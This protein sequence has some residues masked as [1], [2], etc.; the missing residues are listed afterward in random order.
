M[1]KR[2]GQERRVLDRL[3]VLRAERRS[4]SLHHLTQRL[5]AAGAGQLDVRR[6]GLGD[7]SERVCWAEDLGR[8][9]DRVAEGGRGGVQRGIDRSDDPIRPAD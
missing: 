6:F 1:V 8:H 9:R 5:V 2:A 4:H 3:R 7:E